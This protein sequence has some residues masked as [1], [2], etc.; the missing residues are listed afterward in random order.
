M[1]ATLAE[2]EAR[3]AALEADRADYKAVLSMVNVLGQQTRERIAVLDATID[4]AEGRL[5]AR[6]DGAEERLAGKLGETDA[7]V[8]AIEENM[9]EIKDLLIAALDRR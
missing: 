2:L 3:V 9:A 7:R 6:I 4:G 8:R 1:S 5:T